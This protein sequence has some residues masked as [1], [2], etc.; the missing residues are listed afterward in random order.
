MVSDTLPRWFVPVSMAGTG[1]GLRPT[2]DG[3][4]AQENPMQTIDDASVLDRAAANLHK[5]PVPAGTTAIVL[6]PPVV[7]QPQGDN[8][9][10]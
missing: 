7:I 10:N 2:G 3:K 9:R 1:L 6:T 5:G 8:L 4:D